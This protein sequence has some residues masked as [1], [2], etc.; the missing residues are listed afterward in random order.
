[1]PG[2]FA[3]EN[4]QLI[5]R[6]DATLKDLED[7]EIERLNK[8]LD[9]SYLTL[10]KDLLAKYP[11]YTAESQPNLLATQRGLL[12]TSELK[13]QLKLINPE[14][15]AEIEARFTKLLGTA[16]AEGTT[17]AE[18]LIKLQAGDDFVKSTAT[19]PIESV[20][21]AA[22]GAKDRLK[23]HGDKFSEEASIIISQ[24]MVQGW[25][26][27]RTA[28]QLRGR[29][30]I[31]KG[32]AETIART[33]IITAQNAATQQSFKANGI[34]YYSRVATQDAAVCAVCAVRAGAVYPV[35]TPVILHPRDR[36]FASP[37]FPDFEESNPS[38]T[39]WLKAHNKACREKTLEKVVEDARAA[40]EKANG[41]SAPKAIWTPLEGYL[42][43]SVLRQAESWSLARMAFNAM[44]QAGNAKLAF[45]L[46]NIA[47]VTNP[48]S[49]PLV[50][51]PFSQQNKDTSQHDQLFNAIL[52]G[53]SVSGVSVSV[54]FLLRTRRR[55]T[56]KRSA[57][58]A[59]RLSASFAKLASETEV[60][61]GKRVTLSIGGFSA[62]G[63]QAGLRHAPIY[64]RFLKN[65]KVVGVENTDF[66][67]KYDI[68]E[69]PVERVADMMARSFKIL[70]VDD[71]SQDSVRLAAAAIAFHERHG[72]WPDLIGHSGGGIAVREAHEILKAYGAE[73]FRSVSLGAP[74]FGF[75][76]LKPEEHL[77]IVNDSEIF[78]NSPQ[79]NGIK[80][81]AHREFVNSFAAH[82]VLEGYFPNEV[83]QTI[84]SSF[85]DDGSLPIREEQAPWQPFTPQ[86]AF[87]L[88]LNNKFTPLALYHAARGRYRD[89]FAESARMAEAMIP[90]VELTDPTYYDQITFVAGGFAGTQ[91]LAGIEYAPYF[92]NILNL[93]QVVGVPIPE[94]DVGPGIFD[95]PVG[96]IVQ[97]WQ[98][99]VGT[100]LITGRNE[101]AVRMAAMAAAHYRKY[102]LPVNLIGYSSGGM[103]ASEA[104]EIL[105]LM[106]VPVKTAT[107]GTAYF[108]FT[109]LP[110]KDMIGLI[111]E[112]DFFG[113]FPVQ[114]RV[115]L[116]DVKKHWLDHYI[117]SPL[118]EFELNRHF[119][120]SPVARTDKTQAVSVPSE[121]VTTD[122]RP[123][124]RDDVL[125][126]TLIPQLTLLSDAEIKLLPA[127]VARKLLAA[128]QTASIIKAPP[129]AI[130]LADARKHLAELDGV[131]VDLD[132]G[133]IYIGRAILER[134]TLLPA[135]ELIG[136]PAQVR[137]EIEGVRI[138]GAL[139]AKPEMVLAARADLAE[140]K[141]SITAIVPATRQTTAIVPAG[142]ASIVPAQ[143]TAIELGTVNWG[144]AV[145]LDKLSLLPEGE[146]AKALPPV[147]QKQLAAYKEKL[148]TGRL[149]PRQI[150]ATS[151]GR[152][153]L[154]IEAIYKK[155]TS[156]GNL[157]D[158]LKA[159][160]RLE[161]PELRALAKIPQPEIPKAA[162]EQLVRRTAQELYRQSRTV[163]R[164]LSR[165][166]G[167]RVRQK[168][169]EIA[170][171]DAPPMTKLGQYR[172]AIVD[173]IAPLATQARPIQPPGAGSTE[174]M[175]V[176]TFGGIQYYSPAIKPN[177]PTTD[178]IRKLTELD[179]PDSMAS[180]I[181]AIYL[182]KQKNATEVFWRK[183]LKL[184]TGRV[185][186]SINLEEGSITLYNGRADIQDTLR[187]AGYLLAYQKFGR[188]DPPQGTRYA[189]AMTE[190]KTITPY[191]FASPAADFADSVA[192]FWLDPDRLKKFNPARYEAISA[193]LDYRHPVKVQPIVEAKPDP[194][195][196]RIAEDLRS[197]NEKITTARQRVQAAVEAK[198]SEQQATKKFQATINK[199]NLPKTAAA[200]EQATVKARDTEA[201]L[202]RLNES[203]QDLE[204]RAAQL[205]NPFNEPYFGAAVPKL[206]EVAKQLK[207]AEK[208]LA[209]IDKTT[210]AA[211][212]IRA[213]IS[214]LETTLADLST[215]PDS[216]K[217]SNRV[218]QLR[219][220]WTQLESEL[221][222]SENQIINLPQSAER[223]EALRDMQRLK[224]GIRAQGTTLETDVAA[225]HRQV[226]QPKIDQLRAVVE[227]L[228]ALQQRA[229]VQRDRIAD[230]QNRIA[231]LPQKLTDLSDD[232]RARYNTVKSAKIAQSKLP[233]RVEQYRTLREAYTA[234]LA[235]YGG[236]TQKVSDDYFANRPA[237]INAVQAGIEE[238][239]AKIN[240]N[241][242]VLASL[243]P[244]SVAW[245]I[246]SNN[247]Q[248]SE[249]PSDL[250]LIL[251]GR[252]EKNKFDK[253]R[254]AAT[255]LSNLLGTVRGG[256]NRIEEQIK[257][258]EGL[259]QTASD[260][261]LAERRR[262][263][264]IRD[265]IADEETISDK[266]VQQMLKGERQVK[267]IDVIRYS[268]QLLGDLEN[269][270]SEFVRLLLDQE[271]VD[272]RTIIDQSALYKRAKE[273]FAAESENTRQTISGE[274]EQGLATLTALEQRLERDRQEPLIFEVGG[275]ARTV[276]DIRAELAEIQATVDKY[277]NIREIN[278]TPS[279]QDYIDPA[280]AAARQA[281]LQRTDA[282]QAQAD[283]LRAELA[284][285]NQEIRK[286]Q[287]AAARG[288]KRGIAT[289]RLEATQRRILKDIAKL[290][291]QPEQEA[292]SGGSQ[293][294]KKV[295]PAPKR[296]PAP[297]TN[298]AGPSLQDVVKLRREIAQKTEDLSKLKSNADYQRKRD[299]IDTLSR[300]LPPVP[301]THQETIQLGGA[302]IAEP[303]TR[304]D[305]LGV[306]DKSTAPTRNRAIEIIKEIRQT[307]QA[308]GDLQVS[309]TAA[310]FIDIA[311]DLE[312]K[313]PSK[314]LRGIVL[315]MLQIANGKGADSLRNLRLSE[316]P[317]G[318]S[319][320][321]RAQQAI[322][323]G[324]KKT[325]ELQKT[326]LAHEMGHHIEYNSPEIRRKA[327]EF[328]LSRATAAEQVSIAEMT[329][330]PGYG[331]EKAYPDD[332]IHPYV[333]KVYKQG[334][335]E[336][337]SM[338]L[339]YFSSPE[340]MLELYQAD[341]EHFLLIVGILYGD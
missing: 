189:Q 43:K 74:Y 104:H 244:G 228:D 339:Q 87:D 183:K 26:A 335:T 326:S 318:R 180:A 280:R 66:E 40:F 24:G 99:V 219:D 19:I 160:F 251:A 336:V 107:V 283:K 310:A 25:G 112:G 72:H 227:S 167:F 6:T 269:F 185:P 306:T 236:N 32:R 333:G 220:T 67:T 240:E 151:Q 154:A 300:Q 75:E 105:R 82:E 155:L 56:Y 60:P 8:A 171:T 210:A 204:Q 226:I 200:S 273:Q 119:T 267:A 331:D 315:E 313:I 279:S 81:P 84:A 294:P 130:E 102:G 23:K 238:R 299:E 175:Q 70:A 152:Q 150:P 192:Q 173:E 143:T 172:Q 257:Y 214:E 54:Y 113:S 325:P 270:N 330:N 86:Q 51:K 158:D 92:Q 209:T 28:E 145:L 208:Q 80:I 159:L 198:A 11:K 212:Q 93:H 252:P 4:L 134:W 117:D 312:A 161:L 305:S 311:P 71:S 63:G 137:K 114:N 165:L 309:R 146:V 55:N 303:L 15:E 286:R 250:A 53:S 37:F 3:S 319:Y 268:N 124:I 61:K 138:K 59:V 288:Q 85:L 247:W 242:T 243:D 261:L 29:L 281:E 290:D 116:P 334:T 332:F 266:Q 176:F 174:D 39:K 33:E 239:L 272:P 162:E 1:M 225:L 169:S 317:R 120:R 276:Q 263:E 46:A 42:D 52:W 14:R 223:S 133:P 181:G 140:F 141:K 316:D 69:Q 103:V 157:T 111:G 341:R 321:N 68:L 258:V 322:Y 298:P 262:W 38:Y 45:D 296:E 10:E 78:A 115:E 73:D 255:E 90:D 338:G 64:E 77:D 179:L 278:V 135:D 196:T 246:D 237:A 101:S 201:S 31:T 91:G 48:L 36:C 241:L 96:N 328:V 27:M 320:G 191:G 83:F 149:D 30:G 233:Q 187:Q 202:D 13:D 199:V 194:R 284:E 260:Q 245:L 205:L 222:A 57:Q 293:K 142:S 259:S 121:V 211:A 65:K 234:K 329:G 297:V 129:S 324:I 148:L 18:E 323:L 291:D 217:E 314:D 50:F 224:A 285:V 58:E 301:T 89:G 144:Q 44:Q 125:I 20:A 34:D 178:L 22:T 110:V 147:L 232:L 195:A 188:L 274:I 88:L 289:D 127:G 229:N 304:L 213:N 139:P 203:V 21:A 235:E 62:M 265:D 118:F 9:Q 131:Q 49:T 98:N 177:S 47:G 95:D 190:G 2:D 136:L 41:L 109:D 206:K 249:P 123:L 94:F 128:K 215:R 337:I 164:G 193:L 184:P 97:N 108:G 163:D 17:L 122:G 231:R 218:A 253:L 282:R 79:L 340:E 153:E 292:I 76:E 277:V 275:K 5:E 156:E 170:K 132:L 327:L 287:E 35:G 106:N 221:D 216:L 186:G 271:G 308:S 248:F 295:R 307:L 230:Y 197:R 256:A 254:G 100:A 168:L 302:L 16:S 126:D 7:A 166:A 12:L 264:Q 207:A 182:S